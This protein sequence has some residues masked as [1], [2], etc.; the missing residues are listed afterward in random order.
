MSPTT[1]KINVIII[2]PFF[3]KIQSI[4]KKMIKGHFPYRFYQASINKFYI[5][6]SK[7]YGPFINFPRSL[8]CSIHFLVEKYSSLSSN[9][10]CFFIMIITWLVKRLLNKKSKKQS[11]ACKINI[12]LCPRKHFWC[13]HYSS[14]KNIYKYFFWSCSLSFYV[15]T[16]WFFCDFIHNDQDLTGFQWK[17]FQ[18]K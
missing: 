6:R 4:E 9:E 17:M 8:V 3:T 2:I 7:R 10:E 12:C 5:V 14:E 1:K 18:L 16:L 15:S 11:N 13:S